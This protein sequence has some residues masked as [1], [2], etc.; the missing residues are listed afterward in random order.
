MF[1]LCWN[2]SQGEGWVVS[3]PNATGSPENPFST[4][5]VEIPV[6]TWPNPL[7]FWLSKQS[8]ATS[9]ALSGLLT[10]ADSVRHAMLQNRAA[11][12]FCF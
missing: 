8:N 1:G 10:D 9:L 4:C 6:D 3:Q 5:L 11:I 2:L 7:Q 12:D